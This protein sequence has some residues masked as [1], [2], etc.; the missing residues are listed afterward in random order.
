[1]EFLISVKKMIIVA[2]V[3]GFV[4]CASM[5]MKVDVP[6][7]FAAEATSLHIKN[8]RG[9]KT[10]RQLAFGSYFISDLKRGWISRNEINNTPGS[11]LGRQQLL[12]LFNTSESDIE[13]FADPL[14][15]RCGL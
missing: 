7:R 13:L 10:P 14:R 11:F 2:S 4:S 12:Q 5:K 3:S 6:S 15:Y 9:L 1:M 8:L